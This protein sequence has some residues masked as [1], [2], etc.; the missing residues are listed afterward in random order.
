MNAPLTIVTGGSR[1]IGAAIS[2]RLV[3]DGH[4]VVIGYR[5]DASA[6]ELLATELSMSGRTVIAVRADTTDE[7]AVID[8]FDASAKI[9]TVSGVVNNAG[10]ARAVGML[11]DNDI[12]TIRADLDVNVIG[13]ITCCKY[14]VTAMAESGG[15][16]VNISSAAATLGSPG[17]YVH[18]A[19]A[20]AAVDTLTVG[21]SK[22][23]AAQNIRVNAVAPGIIETDFHRDRRRPQKMASSIP[24]GRPGVPDEIAGAVSWL[25]SDDARY[26][27]GTVI[28]V[29]GGM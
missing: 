7:Q 25:L 20:K 2:R 14:A 10:S 11:A 28:R 3:A 1:G 4:D 8:L 6:A 24:V 22:E 26:A 9:G 19:A 29:A 15:S 21:L 12:E 5:S 18:Y 17:M 13:V 23:V 16:I 27:T